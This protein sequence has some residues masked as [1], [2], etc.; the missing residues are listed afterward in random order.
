VRRFAER[1]VAL[2]Q[3]RADESGGALSP[4]TAGGSVPNVSVDA[5]AVITA[6]S[7]LAIL[8]KATI[9]FTTGSS[10][11]AAFKALYEAACKLEP[12]LAAAKSAEIEQQANDLFTQIY[13]NELTIPQVVEILKRYRKSKDASEKD[14]YKCMVRLSSFLLFV[15]FFCLPPLFSSL[16]DQVKNLFDEYQFKRI[17]KYNEPNLKLTGVLFGTL[18]QHKLVSSMTLGIALRY[19]LEALRKPPQ[20]KMFRFGRFALDQFRGRLPEWPQYCQ[21]MEQIAHLAELFPELAAFR[22]G[23]AGGEGAGESGADASS[24]SAADDVTPAR[25]VFISLFDLLFF[26]LLIY[27]LHT[28]SASA[29]LITQVLRS[30]GV[31]RG[32]GCR[33]DRC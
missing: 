19:V 4:A 26:C 33:G 8:F 30:G 14:V 17:E 23:V 31:I 11:E 12:A 28:S 10:E 16:L 32:V 13:G 21:H 25:S 24:A 22:A 2:L 5:S 6:T 29:V 9:V 18:I 20:H 27:S 7:V 1:H 3:S 15:Q